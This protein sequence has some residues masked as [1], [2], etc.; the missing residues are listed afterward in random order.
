MNEITQCRSCGAEIVWMKTHKGKNIPVDL[1]D[2]GDALR[3]RVLEEEIFEKGY[4]DTHF[5]SCPNADQHRKS[6]GATPSVLPSHEIAVNTKRLNTAI[7][8]LEDIA[9]KDPDGQRSVTLARAA[10]SQIRMMK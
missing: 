5:N 4:M 9:T 8:A 3:D 6:Q 2:P 10:L 1:P 7:A